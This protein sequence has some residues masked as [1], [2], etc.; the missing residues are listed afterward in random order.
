MNNAAA[1]DDAELPPE[2]RMDDYDDEPGLT[3]SGNGNADSGVDV[4]IDGGGN[5][6]DSDDLDA[7]DEDEEMDGDD[8]GQE[9]EDEATAE[10]IGVNF[11]EEPSTGQVKFSKEGGKNPLSPPPF[12]VGSKGMGGRRGQEGLRRG[13]CSARTKELDLRYDASFIPP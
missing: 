10:A 13:L 4:D 12:L 3:V 11:L 8:E 5:G 7:M 2:L 9:E 1:V 6:D